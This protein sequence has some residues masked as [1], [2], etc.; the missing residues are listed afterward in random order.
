MGGVFKGVGDRMSPEKE[1]AG[2]TP[3][4]YEMGESPELGG[5]RN[6]SVLGGKTEESWD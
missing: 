4:E 6:K 5:V 1:E 2:N 3:E